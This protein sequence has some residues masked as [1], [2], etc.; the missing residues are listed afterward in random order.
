MSHIF[1]SYSHKDKKYVHKLQDAL[2]KEGFEVWIDDRIDY[3]TEWPKVI[4]NQLD[5][6]NAFIVVVSEDAYESEWVQNEVARAKRKGKPFFPLLLQGDPWLSVEA[7]Q[8]VNVTGGLLPPEKFYKRLEKVTPKKRKSIFQEGLQNS[9][10]VTLRSIEDI[11]AAM[12]E[13]IK[14]LLSDWASTANTKRNILRELG[15]IARA[16]NLDEEKN[17]IAKIVVKGLFDK[18]IKIRNIAIAILS[19][20]GPPAIEPVLEI[21]LDQIPGRK[22]G[23]WVAMDIFSL[24]GIEAIPNLISNVNKYKNGDI[25]L[26]VLCYRMPIESVIGA[27]KDFFLQT[28]LASHQRETVFSKLRN[29]NNWYEAELKEFLHK[30]IKHPDPL[31]RVMSSKWYVIV[32]PSDA[33]LAFKELLKDDTLVEHSYNQQTVSA[34]VTEALMKI[35]K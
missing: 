14:L 15:L 9:E 20:I 8:Y 25:I 19:E 11:D 1:I 23:R 16:S 21:R 7:T 10:E 27:L 26:D 30:G 34:F 31:V 18:D 32:F 4:Q 6:C 12:V 13:K 33:R 35:P 2:Q 28:E 24:M 5:I 3:G 17:F 22:R 29:Y